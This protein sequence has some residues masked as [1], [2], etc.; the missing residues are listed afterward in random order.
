MFHK[1]VE[2][3][4]LPTTSITLLLPEL[5]EPRYTYDVENMRAPLVRIRLLPLAPLVPSTSTP[6]LVR[7]A[8][9]TPPPS[10]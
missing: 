6:T 8:L 9:P 3:P 2:V 10:T 5:S 1:L 7:I 4:P